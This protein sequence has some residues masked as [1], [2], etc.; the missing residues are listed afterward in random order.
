MKVLT[1]NNLN[2][3]SREERASAEREREGGDPNKVSRAGL[4][5]HTGRPVQFDSMTAVGH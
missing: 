1:V 2:V 4:W 5:S 3:L